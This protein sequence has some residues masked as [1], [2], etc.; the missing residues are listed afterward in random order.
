VG[1]NSTQK[2]HALQRSTMIETVPF[3][4]ITPPGRSFSTPEPHSIIAAE[5]P[6]GC[7]RDHVAR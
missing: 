2:P 7:D 4:D 1:Q 5:W 6:S 3:V